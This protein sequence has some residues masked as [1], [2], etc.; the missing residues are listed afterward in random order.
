M[1]SYGCN[2]D[3]ALPRQNEYVMIHDPLFVHAVIKKSND[4]VLFYCNQDEARRIFRQI[5]GY[6]ISHQVFFGL[7]LIW[8]WF[9]SLGVV[10]YF[11]DITSH[12]MLSC[13]LLLNNTTTNSENH[14]ILPWIKLLYGHRQ[15]GN[16]GS[17]HHC[18]GFV[19]LIV[20]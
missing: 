20:L 13:Y 5:K 7:S 2:L 18:A 4:N 10:T 17:A 1:F 12:V 8:N 3:S 11:G 19:C 9:E 6:T 15:L 16:R 14:G